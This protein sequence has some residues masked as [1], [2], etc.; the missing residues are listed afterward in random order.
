MSVRRAL[1][2]RGAGISVCVIGAFDAGLLR[3][4]RAVDT[5]KGTAETK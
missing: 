2:G 5:G 4:H 3:L 1:D